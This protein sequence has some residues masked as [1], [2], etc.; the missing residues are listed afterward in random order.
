MVPPTTTT[1]A[2]FYFDHR[3]YTQGVSGPSLWG[4]VALGVLAGLLAGLVL[5]GTWKH[6]RALA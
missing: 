6:D 1:T 3:V 5:F 2:L 4:I